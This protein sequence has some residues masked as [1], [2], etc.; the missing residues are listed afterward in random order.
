MRSTLSPKADPGLG[1][2]SGHKRALWHARIGLG[3]V[4][5]A[6]G[7][8]KLAGG[9]ERWALLGQAMTYIGVDGHATLWGLAAAAGEIAGGAALLSGRLF[10]PGC[11]LLMWIMV[12]ASAM[13]VGRG[14]DVIR[15]AIP[16]TVGMIL[17][18]L[19]AMGPPARTRSSRASS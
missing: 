10:R 14:S 3:V 9:P 18:V 12:V 13:H 16:M 1:N 4:F 7:A 17:A 15:C 19:A 5:L 2:S 11:A 8:V 6:L